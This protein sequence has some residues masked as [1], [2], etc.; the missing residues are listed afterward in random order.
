[1][2]VTEAVAWISKDD[3]RAASH[4]RQAVLRIARLLGEFPETGRR[5]IEL[6]AD[7]IRFVAMPDFPYILVYQADVVPP[8][9]LRVL[10]S[11]RDLPE[12]LKGKWEE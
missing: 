7:S 4:L 5:R 9:I 1:M 2:D 12:V 3:R 11:A 10:H 6:A 8:R